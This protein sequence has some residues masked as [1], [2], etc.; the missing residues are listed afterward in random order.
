MLNFHMSCIWP[1]VN[2][3]FLHPLCKF[4]KQLG[5]GS[6]YPNYRRDLRANFCCP[7]IISPLAKSLNKL[8]VTLRSQTAFKKYAPII[9]PGIATIAQVASQVPRLIFQPVITR[10]RSFQCVSK[11]HPRCVL[12]RW[13]YICQDQVTGLNFP[14]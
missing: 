13:Q 3:Q 11:A 1:N 2:C 14:L 5:M 8:Y 4:R 12:K 7:L 9:H 10:K 6:R